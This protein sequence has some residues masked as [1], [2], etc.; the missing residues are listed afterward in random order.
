LSIAASDRESSGTVHQPLNNNY[1]SYKAGVTLMLS[2]AGGRS[3]TQHDKE[4]GRS[5]FELVICVE[6]RKADS[7]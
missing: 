2:S 7:V 3:R 4:E 6:G 1:N 5:V